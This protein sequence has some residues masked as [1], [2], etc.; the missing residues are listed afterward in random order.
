MDWKFFANEQPEWGKHLYILVEHEDWYD[1]P[2]LA[3]YVLACTRLED[4]RYVEVGAN[5]K[6]HEIVEDVTLVAWRYVPDELTHP[7]WDS[8]MAEALSKFSAQAAT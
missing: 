4:G 1:G 2:L 7:R 3:A 6:D 5:K 8:A